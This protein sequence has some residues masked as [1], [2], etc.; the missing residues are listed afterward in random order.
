V[1]L[2]ILAVALAVAVPA[3]DRLAPGVSLRATARDAAALLREARSLAISGN[4]EVAVIVDLEARS[5]GIA[6]SRA[7]ERIDEDLGISLF[8]AAEERLDRGAGRIRFYPDGSST[9]GR[10]RLTR[11][12]NRYDV[13]VSWVTGG[14]TIRD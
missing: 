13:T 3:F 6:G 9:G 5:L 11:G 4:R 1:V 12:G 14:V 8:S 7:V 2:A 10:I